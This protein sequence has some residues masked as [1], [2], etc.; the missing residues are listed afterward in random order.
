MHISK[1]YFV[2]LLINLQSIFLLFSLL[3]IFNRASNK[4]KMI[5]LSARARPRCSFVMPTMPAL[6]PTISIPKSGTCWAWTKGPELNCM[7]RLSHTRTNPHSPYAP[8]T[9]RPKVQEPCRFQ[10][11]GGR[12][13]AA[14]R[15][16]AHVGAWMAP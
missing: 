4:K 6:A 2:K 16:C 10:A 3:S 5:Y 8:P 15:P 14:P 1:V 12:G 13:A 7:L 11:A 9:L